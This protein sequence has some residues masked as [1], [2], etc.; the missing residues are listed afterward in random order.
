[1]I[2]KGKTTMKTLLTIGALAASLVAG[3]VTSRTNVT[4]DQD[5]N[6]SPEAAKTALSNIS[7]AIIAVDLAEAKAEIMTNTVK[8]ATATLDKAVKLISE[9]EDYALVDMYLTGARITEG[10][11]AN[12]STSGDVE[13]V[14]G[15]AF[16]GTDGSDTSEIRFVDQITVD[17]TS[18]E[19]Y[20]L[21]TLTWAYYNG[22]FSQPKILA[23]TYANG[24]YTEIEMSDPVQVSVGE[25]VAYQSTVELDANIYGSSAFFKVTAKIA[26][27]V[28]D[29]KTWYIYT[30]GTALDGVLYP[31]TGYGVKFHIEPPGY[32]TSMS[33]I[34]KD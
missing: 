4:I 13:E 17:R 19:G 22:S 25:I 23:A 15:E 29:G 12:T 24:E 1:M 14:V 5:G 11:T 31:P 28:D 16:N 9:H 7:S 34:K 20:I 6:I 21:V 32:I 33:L 27:P 10:T 26:A 30:D 18:K 3:A 8:V 2:S